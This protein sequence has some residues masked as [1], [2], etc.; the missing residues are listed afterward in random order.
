MA[1]GFSHVLGLPQP[2]VSDSRGLV[3]GESLTFNFFI[4]KNSLAVAPAL[5]VPPVLVA[6]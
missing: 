3:L 5:T 6:I 1:L 2:N 4:K